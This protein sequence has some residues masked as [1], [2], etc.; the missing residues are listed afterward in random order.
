MADDKLWVHDDPGYKGTT[1][2]LEQALQNW[3]PGRRRNEDLTKYKYP[4]TG[5]WKD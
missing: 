4:A 3:K 2:R 5:P 1:D